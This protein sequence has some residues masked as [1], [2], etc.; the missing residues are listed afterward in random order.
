MATARQILDIAR[1]E[2]GTEESP[3]NSNNVKYS[4]WYPMV[5]SPWC[6]MFVSWVLDRANVEGYRHAYTPAGADLFKSRG[7]WTGNPKPGDVVYFDFPDSL[8]RIQHVGFVEGVAGDTIT[9]IEGNTSVTSNDNGGKV[10]R[11]SRPRSYIV[12]YG[13]PPYDGEGR[14]DPPGGRDSAK[15]W[16]GLGDSGGDI[17][18]WQR[19]LNAVMEADLDVDG[20]FGPKTLEVTKKFQRKYDLEVDGQVGPKSLHKM[21]KV[22]GELKGEKDDRPPILELHDDGRWVKKAQERLIAHGY[23][24]DPYGADGDFGSVTAKAVKAFKK[25]NGLPV[26]AV[27]GPHAWEALTKAM[28]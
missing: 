6:A 23:E 5:G 17:R 25:A 22:F 12:G 13:R 27:I 26:T 19:Q 14:V 9:C 24:L 7:R 8:H 28:K 4:R 2:L 11:R 3:P 21:E 20:E 18:V 10:M 1:R 15:G 16:F